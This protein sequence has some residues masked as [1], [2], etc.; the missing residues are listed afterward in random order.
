MS[1]RPCYSSFSIWMLCHQFIINR[2]FIFLMTSGICLIISGCGEN[3]NTSGELSE[4]ISQEIISF[5]TNHTQAGDLKWSLIANNAIFLENH[6][7]LITEPSVK[8]YENPEPSQNSTDKL[9][10]SSPKFI[11]ITGDNGK[12]D[13]RTKD[14]KIFGNVEGVNDNGTLY[15]NEL[16]WKDKEGLIYA[17]GKVKIVRGDSVML[18]QNMTADPSL[19]LVNMENVAF[20]LYP[21]DE[22]IEHNGELEK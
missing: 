19:E 3:E 10:N 17:P 6:E 7:V 12:L 15:T 9:E 14:M 16:Y 13:D 4:K 22:K 20:N 21:K 2:R 5:T 11:T 18:G 8:I 1:S